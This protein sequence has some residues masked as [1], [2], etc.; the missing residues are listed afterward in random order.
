MLGLIGKK[1]GM[2]QMFDE[3]GK[4]IPITIVHIEPNLVVGKRVI[5]K[6]GY[7]ATILGAFSLK[8]KRIKKTYAGQFKNG[9]E[10]RKRLVEMR[11]FE[12]E[13][14][15]GDSITVELFDGIAFVDVRGTSK[16]KGFQGEVKKYHFGGGKASHG[17]KHHREHGSTGM[18]TYPHHTF[19]GTRM[20]SRMG[21][22]QRTIPNLKLIRIDK[23]K[24]SLLIQGA[25]P[26]HRNSQVIVL[27]AK[28]KK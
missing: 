7:N 17:S 6:N 9:L 18:G 13:Y 5:D 25:I 3:K 8:K 24:N 20:A 2:T 11:D 14:N 28:K 27:K 19:K 16:G 15:V 4:F 26:G 10:V 21:N 22:V 23:E 12:K 1:I